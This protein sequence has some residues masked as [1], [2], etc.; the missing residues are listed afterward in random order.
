MEQTF[1]MIK[2]DGVQRNLVCVLHSII[3]LGN[4]LN[5]VWLVIVQLVEFRSFNFSQVVWV[6]FWFSRYSAFIC[7]ISLLLC[8][9]GWSYLLWFRLVKSLEGLRRR[10]S[11][12]KVAY[13][14]NLLV[15]IFFI[16]SLRILPF[17]FDYSFF[18]YF[19]VCLIPMIIGN[20]VQRVLIRFRL[21]SLIMLPLMM[22]L[23]P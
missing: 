19:F 2:P 6:R 13:F 9:V 20:L 11:L 4:F 8:L 12:W 18:V 22:N 21:K 3:I 14:C 7:T 10:V 17:A 1:I 16:L 15:L 23:N 5:F